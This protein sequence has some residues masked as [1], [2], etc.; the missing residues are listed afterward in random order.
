MTERKLTTKPET[1]TIALGQQ[2][3][4]EVLLTEEQLDELYA[5]CDLPGTEYRDALVV[6]FELA[7]WTLKI[8]R[9][10]FGQRAE[11]QAFREQLYAAQSLAK[12][13][14]N[15]LGEMLPLLKAEFN[16]HYKA[17]QHYNGRIN[18]SAAP[19][20]LLDVE[21][22]LD[23]LV[24]TPLP[25]KS[26]AQSDDAV[27]YVVAGLMHAMIARLEP[28]FVH[29]GQQPKRGP[30]F[31]WARQARIIQKFLVIA[32][33]DPEHAQRYTDHYVTFLIGKIRKSDTPLSK[34]DF[35]PALDAM[36]KAVSDGKENG[37]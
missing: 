8:C 6:E 33:P 32:E 16:A 1:L 2:L 34:Y 17:R 19:L 20:G 7:A 11:R 30:W 36:I 5:L 24:A 10:L 22:L 31:T 18:D 14:S 26:H 28:F 27:E 29:L 37:G 3:E 25:Y 12:R 35:Q 4:S 23:D 21:Y 15:V 9:V 13:L